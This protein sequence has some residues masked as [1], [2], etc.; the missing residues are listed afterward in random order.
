MAKKHD[1]PQKAALTEMI[2]T[3][4]KEINVKVK[5]GT[6][7]NSI[8]RD[9]ISVILQVTLDEDAMPDIRL[10]KILLLSPVESM[11]VRLRR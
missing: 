9:I 7:D 4:M 1:L 6:E 5:D 10:Q 3:Y 11:P 8:M 2:A